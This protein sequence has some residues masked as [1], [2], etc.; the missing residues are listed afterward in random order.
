MKGRLMV[1]KLEIEQAA[2]R[3]RKSVYESEYTTGVAWVESLVNLSGNDSLAVML[4]SKMAF[5]KV[6][7]L[8]VLKAEMKA[9]QADV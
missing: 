4:E 9:L 1:R 2:L 6:A 8:G 7:L 3:E 5:D